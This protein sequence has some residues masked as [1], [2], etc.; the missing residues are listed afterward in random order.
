MRSCRF[1]PIQRSSIKALNL[2]FARPCGATS[3]CPRLRVRGE[4]CLLSRAR[5]RSAATAAHSWCWRCSRAGAFSRDSK[6]AQRA[7]GFHRSAF[8]AF[9]FMFPTHAADE[10]FEMLA[11]G[12][13]G[14]FVNRHDRLLANSTTYS[15]G[16]Q[17]R[18]AIFY[19]ASSSLNRT[20]SWP[21]LAQ[22]IPQRPAHKLRISATSDRKACHTMPRRFASRNAGHRDQTSRSAN[23]PDHPADRSQ[24]EAC[25]DSV[26]S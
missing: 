7:L 19:P 21:R 8:G 22:G 23:A 1:T 10:L 2:F 11:A 6:N 4:N 9:G 26:P 16:L 13:T 15:I 3:P 14:V 18:P 17:R 5:A 20:R 24:P 12:F 25:R